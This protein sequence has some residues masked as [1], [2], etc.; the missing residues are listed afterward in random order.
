MYLIYIRVA[1]SVALSCSSSKYRARLYTKLRITVSGTACSKITYPTYV[2]FCFKPCLS[3]SSSVLSHKNNIAIKRAIDCGRDW[4]RINRYSVTLFLTEHGLL[5]NHVRLVRWVLFQAV[6]F[7]F[8]I[9]ISL[10]KPNILVNKYSVHNS[11]LGLRS[12]GYFLVMHLNSVP[13]N[14]YTFKFSAII[15]YSLFIIN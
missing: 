5:Q 13:K 9:Q 3:C 14:L 10:L 6:P 12:S 15:N 2:G 11:T 8:F 7:L 1:D 4:L